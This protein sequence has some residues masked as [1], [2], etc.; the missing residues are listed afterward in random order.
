MTQKKGAYWLLAGGFL[1]VIALMF[2]LQT[3]SIQVMDSLAEL[4]TKMYR[5]PLTVSNAV[6]EANNRIVSMHRH[7]KDVALARN[8]ADLDRAVARVA[9]EERQVYQRFD[10]V[11]ERFLGDKSKIEAAR[12]AFTEWREIRSEVIELT[13]AGR[14]DEAAAITKGKGAEHVE[15]LSARMD[16]L[17]AFA[18]SKAS[19]F[20]A[21]SQAQHES[22]RTQL[23]GV[24]TLVIVVSGLVAS[25][26]VYRIHSG[27]K[28][29]RESE[30]R[31]RSI[32]ETS[33]AAMVI[34]VDR[35]GN[36]VHWNPA[37]ERA[38]GYSKEE[39]AGRPLTEIMPE[40]YRAGHLEGFRRAI[41][42]RGFRFMGMSLEFHGLRKN[43]E[44]F[45]IEFS[46][47]TWRQG[48]ETY[49]SA[50]MH[51]ITERKASESRFRNLVEGSIQGVI[52]HRQWRIL[53]ANQSMARICGYDSIDDLLNVGT[54]ENLI[55]PQERQRLRSIRQ[56][57]ERGER[58]EDFLE[59]EFLRADGSSI[60]LE[61]VSNVIDWNGQQA[62]QSTVIDIT[63]RK[64][65]EA[66][67]REAK[68][69]AENANAVKSQFLA[70]MSH[71]LRTPLN[72][73]LGFAQMLQF[74]PKNP[75]SS[76]QAEHVEQILQGGNHLLDLVNEILDLAR[77]EADQVDLALGEVDIQSIVGDCI[78]LVSPLGDQ[79]GVPILNQVEDR[80]VLAVRTD[81]RR[82]KQ[83]LINLLSNAVKFNHREGRVT[84]GARETK[85]GFMR[86]SVADTGPGI[87]KADRDGVFQMFHRVGADPMLAREGAGIGLT[88][89]KL[90]VERM[91]GHIG[92]ESEEGVGSTFWIELPLASNRDTVIWTDAMRTGVNAIDKDH[93]KI[94][95]LINRIMRSTCDDRDANSA[96]EELVTFTRYHF[97]REEMIMEICDY[98]NAEKHRREH[99]AVSARIDDLV[100]EW[101]RNRNAEHLDR[102]RA[103][104][105][106]THLDHV[107]GEFD[108]AS[109]AGGK[110]E[111]IEKVLS[112]LR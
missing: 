110:E 71:E 4:T 108:L 94:V 109:F 48:E 52:I 25:F 75:L 81:Q 89:S 10:T 47:G 62:I 80:P 19:A 63:D 57:R 104:F 93:Q 72:A 54:M 51:D 39:I 59:A 95:S 2:V 68:E 79:K 27:E 88:V 35:L 50:V 66:Q 26:V 98:P 100:D 58:A 40:R 34:V 76:A 73:V 111:E 12:T 18:R 97:R 64:R 38:F 32:S 70:S 28:R 45:P 5:H 106:E 33:S 86:L 14:Y 20:L 15:L 77:V 3:G 78:E 30:E 65:A 55:A 107:L 46:L 49:F 22:S 17:I 56:S 41:D 60:W 82:L 112:L 43:G 91:G 42:G 8:A 92:L 101:R 24:M 99:R 74:D 21:D 6:L 103:L 53:F 105:R 87:S 84:V 67:M 31:F 23:Y 90:L 44:E 37:A 1:L 96:V 102:L 85:D 29:L 9:A 16:D 69:D 61:L 36:V 13:R 11:S 83:V 7:M